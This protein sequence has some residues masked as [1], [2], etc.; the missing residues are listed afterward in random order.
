MVY[1]YTVVFKCNYTNSR[2]RDHKKDHKKKNCYIASYNFMARFK[3]YLRD[4]NSDNPTVVQLHIRWN[5]Q[6]LKFNTGISIHPN[7]WDDKNRVIKNN[8]SVVNSRIFNQRLRNILIDSE[9]AYVEFTDKNKREPT[10]SELKSIVTSCI[11][12]ES[13]QLNLLSFMDSH[14]RY[15]VDGRNPKTGEPYSKE[16]IKTYRLCYNK[17]KEFEQ[18]ERYKVDFDSVNLR[19]HRLFLTYLQRKG[20]KA[21]YQGKLIKL[22]ITFMNEAK[23]QG[24]TNNMDFKNRKFYAPKED[25]FSI[26]LDNEELNE[27]SKLTLTDKPRLEN[28]RDLFLIGC[29]TGLRFSDIVRITMND[30]EINEFGEKVIY[31]KLQKTK[32]RIAIPVLPELEDLL[33][34]RNNILPRIITNQ[35]LNEYIKEACQLVPSLTKQTY[36]G[37]EFIGKFKWQLVASHTARRSFATNSAKMGMSTRLIMQ[38]TGHT[39]EAAFYRYI[40][41]SPNENAVLF[42]R[43]Y[44]QLQKSKQTI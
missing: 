14:I 41:L 2:K 20:Y 31:I 11:S 42:S 23:E 44:Q 8:R 3:L 29:Y 38:I 1:F 40:R 7:Y 28:A 25:V 13:L 39:T 17:L 16:T 43:Q 10:I 26:Y 35:K 18:S 24:L 27:I 4:R 32:R 36:I 5:A 34:R 22:I 19:F 21:N 6:R 30:I 37:S 33:K 9:N 12:G 15:M